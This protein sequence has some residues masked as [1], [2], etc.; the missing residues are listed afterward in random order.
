MREWNG[1][2]RQLRDKTTHI[3]H[4]ENRP[5]YSVFWVGSGF[6][7]LYRFLIIAFLST[8]TYENQELTRLRNEHLTH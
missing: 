6:L 5:I 7:R 4:K 1:T 2:A 8:M 3:D